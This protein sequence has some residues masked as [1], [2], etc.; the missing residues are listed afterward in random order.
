MS[1]RLSAGPMETFH[2]STSRWGQATLLAG[3]VISLSGPLYLMFGLGYWPGAETVSR[4]W[5]AIAAVF[6][7]L[8]IAEPITYYP[9]LGSAAT[10]QAFMIGNVSNKLLPS[11]LSAQNAVGA[12]QGTAK[13]EITTVTAI[14][15]AVS[16]HLVSLLVF[17]GVLGTWIMS[18][19]PEAV[20]DVFGY[21]VPAIFGP[22]LIQAVMSAGQRRTIPI[23]LC[24]GAVGV[25]VLVPLVPS[26]SVYAMAVC[27]LAAVVLSVLLRDRA[28]SRNNT[29]ETEGKA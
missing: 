7:V 2:R 5:L 12:K 8:W 13:A 9:M 23:A 3:L 26:T 16:V 19:I 10:Y 11:A 28:G 29:E 17:V 20:R 14:V 25:F 15:G 1:T 24:C 6:G 18:V 22:M 4:T 21:V 27:T